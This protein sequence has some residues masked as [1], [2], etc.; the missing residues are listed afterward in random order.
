MGKLTDNVLIVREDHS[1]SDRRVSVPPMHA[2]LQY[3]L[4]VVVLSWTLYLWQ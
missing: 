1:L 4:C 2:Y 3:G